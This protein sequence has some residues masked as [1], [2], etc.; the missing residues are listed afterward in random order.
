MCQWICGSVSVNFNSLVMLRVRELTTAKLLT[1]QLPEIDVYTKTLVSGITDISNPGQGSDFTSNTQDRVSMVAKPMLLPADV[2][3]LPKGQAFALLEGG[4]LW[5][6]R[7]PL[8]AAL[9]DVL[10]PDNLQKIAQYME[11]NYRTG[12]TWW[13]AAT[14]ADS[15][16]SDQLNNVWAGI[17]P[18][19]DTEEDARGTE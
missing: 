13:T 8:P 14:L 5:K 1:D 17:E 10:M 12:E 16:D 6:I 2:I 7:M 11:K 3:Q 9:D 15:S 19:S 4:K 18:D